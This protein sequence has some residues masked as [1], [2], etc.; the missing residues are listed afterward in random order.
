MD[1]ESIQSTITQLEELAKEMESEGSM[2]IGDIVNYTYEG[3]SGVALIESIMDENANIRVMAV[4]GDNYEPTDDVYTVPLAD[5]SHEGSMAEEVEDGDGD[6]ETAV[7]E[8]FEDVAEEE[9]EEEELKKGMF[10]SWNSKHGITKG[11][12]V[13]V[14]TDEPAIIPETGDEFKSDNPIALIEV[15]QEVESKYEDTGVHV[16]IDSSHLSAIDPLDVKPRKLMVKMNN[17]EVGDKADDDNIGIIKGLGSAYGKVDLGGDTVAKGAYTQT[18]NH[19]DGKVQLMFNHGAKV[20][21]VAGVAYLED[22]EEGLMVEGKMPLSVPSIKDAYEIIKF[23]L[24]EGKSLGMSI[25][26]IPVKSEPGPNGT[27]VLKEI[28]LEEMTITP[29]PM[30]TSARIRDAKDRKFNYHTKRRGWQS[31]VNGKTRK[32]N[33]APTGNH[34]QKDEYKSLT[35]L[36][37]EIK[38][39]IEEHHV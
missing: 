24:S 36:L 31:V 33:D 11:R 27:R 19:N 3:E 16:A 38:N 15:Y 22:S 2:Q 1:L 14:V 7:E 28:A 4:A 6:D 26:Y 23:M 21:D 29:W 18:I 13:D 30:D 39:N 32:E 37:S 10:V 34:A 20:S 5:L 35:E 12:I 8:E 25:G 17:Y 9:I